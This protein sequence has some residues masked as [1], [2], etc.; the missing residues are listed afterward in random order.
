MRLVILDGFTLNPGDLDWSPL[1]TLAGGGFDVHERTPAGEVIARARGAEI[2]LTN[3]V[4]LDRVVL[5]A[6]RPAGLRYV[7]VLA[8]GFN[9]VDAAA[10]RALGVTVTNVP[11]YGTMTVAQA[12]IALLLELTNGVGAQARDVRAGRWSGSADWCYYD[13]PPVEL[14]GLTLGLV[15]FGAIAQAVARLGQA[16][17]MRVLAHRRDAGKPPEVPGVT[18]VGL[19]EVFT[20]S[21]V[22]S[23]H[24]PLTDATRGLVN[25]ERLARLKPTAFLL[26]TARGPLIVERDLADALNAGR[27]AGAGL[28][29]LA[30]EPPAADHPLL[31]ARHC[32]IT[33]HVAWAARA[34]RQRLLATAAANVRAFL[35]GR[36]ENVVN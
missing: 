25:A 9:V 16:F 7:G 22:V 19:E 33:P 21:D 30:A 29:V 35:A 3:K 15:G 10:A 23:L 26:N 2:V 8:T 31:A 11:S 4:A 18:L 32:V 13:V 28:D 14:D 12:T 24:C 27:L 6:L 36:P 5:E 1:A 34:A 17:G 20:Q